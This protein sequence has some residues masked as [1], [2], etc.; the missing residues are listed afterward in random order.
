V[1]RREA[2]RTVCRAA[3]SDLFERAQLIDA[4]DLDGRRIQNAAF[5]LAAELYRRAG[6][7]RDAQVVDE[8]Q[9][10]LDLGDSRT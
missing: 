9:L 4:G 7:E 3:A 8:R 1:N 2:K 5:E 10:E 6:L